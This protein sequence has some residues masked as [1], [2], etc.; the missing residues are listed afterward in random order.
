MIRFPDLCSS[1]FEIVAAG[2]WAARRTLAA[3]ALTDKDRPTPV[4]FQWT[5]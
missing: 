5:I 1:L 3:I 4:F 2:C